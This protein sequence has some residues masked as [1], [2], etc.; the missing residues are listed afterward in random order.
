MS[1]QRVHVRALLQKAPHYRQISLCGSF[2]QGLIETVRVRPRKET[3]GKTRRARTPMT[4]AKCLPIFITCLFIVKPLRVFVQNRRGRMPGRTA[5]RL[6]K[7]VAP[8]KDSVC[9]PF[10][11]RTGG[12]RHE[13][14]PRDP[15]HPEEKFPR[16]YEAHEAL[17]KEIH[18]GPAPYR[19][20]Q[21][22]SSDRHLRGRQP[23]SIA[24]DAH[25]KGR[26]AGLTDG[27]IKQALLLLIPTV[28]FPTFMEIL[29]V[30]RGWRV[31]GGIHEA[32]EAA[33]HNT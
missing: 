33:D 30:S 1:V 24:G 9:Q 2:Q 7:G 15:D 23:P 4:T 5:M 31:T 10:Q 21:D 11:V 26:E 29:R 12:D 6:T 8:S 3:P 25:R 17:G 27:E 28:G 13:R 14:Y 32:V 19:R 20:G 16:V 22:G 18:E